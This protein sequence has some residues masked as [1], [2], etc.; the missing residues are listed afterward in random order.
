MPNKKLIWAHLALLGA[1]I[2]YGVNYSV[3]K[4]LM[5]QYLSPFGFIF[6]RVLGAL[7]LFWLFTSFQKQEKIG[8]KDWFR[9]AACGLFGVAGNQLMF[10]YGLNLTSP[11]NAAIIM[12]SNPILVLI[13]SAWLIKE[14]ITP[15]KVAGIFLGLAGAAGLILQGKEL[16]VTSDNF[17]GDLFIFLNA[18]S[19]AV[20]LVLV[21]PLMSRYKPITV[22]KWVFL[23][24][25]LFV[26]PFGFQ[27]FT[28]VQW[29]TFDSSVWASFLFVVVGTTFLAYLFNIYGLKQLNPSV[30]STYIYSQPLIATVV[31]LMLDQ[32]RL[33]LVKIVS[34]AFIFAGVYLV[35]VRKRQT[36]AN[37]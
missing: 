8:R 19:Y 25:F 20:Y 12:T 16:S 21:K 30:V 33:D 31:A 32:D 17:L 18:T 23:F 9:L 37:A 26:T 5:P 3:A 27:Q 7:L 36:P 6:C 4:E 24:G 22:I 1:N 2:I 13:M 15:V 35:S 34:A 11:I 10:F 28:E 14:R 29:H